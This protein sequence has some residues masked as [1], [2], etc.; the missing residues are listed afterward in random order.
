MSQQLRP[1][2]VV[3]MSFFSLKESLQEPRIS[4]LNL[5][6]LG[7]RATVIPEICEVERGVSR[8]CCEPW[9]RGKLVK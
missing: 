4:N 3:A 2:L 9:K 7:G 1:R 5:V 6:M 8:Y